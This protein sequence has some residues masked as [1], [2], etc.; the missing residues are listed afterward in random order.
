MQRILVSLYILFSFFTSFAQE[1][2]QDSA[3]VL[4]PVMVTGF[5]QQVP[6]HRSPIGVGVL[7]RNSADFSNKTS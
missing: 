7:S 3:K 5:E 4:D 2:S 6:L 1:K